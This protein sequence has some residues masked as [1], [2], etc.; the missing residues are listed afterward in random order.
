M[1]NKHELENNK[2][3]IQKYLTRKEFWSHN[4]LKY[5]LL[6]RKISYIIKNENK[7]DIYY[8]TNNTSKNLTDYVNRLNELGI[9]TAI[10]KILSPLLPLSEYLLVNKIEKIYL[11]GTESFKEYLKTLGCKNNLL[12]A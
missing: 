1:D 8:M 2:K 12:E 7:Y 5:N 9:N 10:D 11:L 4:Y 6:K 3:K